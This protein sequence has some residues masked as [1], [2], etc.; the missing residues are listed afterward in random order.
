MRI[1]RVAL[2]QS[3]EEHDL[4]RKEME[5]RRHC[6]GVGAKNT[7]TFLD[8]LEDAFITGRCGFKNNRRQQRNFHF[9]CRLG[10]SDQLV[11]VVQRQGLQNP[12]SELDFVAVEIVLAQNEAERL[13]YQEVGAAGVTKDVP[14]ATGLLNSTVAPASHRGTAAR[15]DHDA[16][17]APERRSHSG[18]AIAS[19]DDFRAGP[20]LAAETR[21]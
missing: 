5:A 20:T 14:P 8:D 13:N 10:P 19:G 4:W 1:Q 3:T 9:I 2:K 16:V 17:A 11:E 12:R 7:R 15:I 6:L 18:I 21:E